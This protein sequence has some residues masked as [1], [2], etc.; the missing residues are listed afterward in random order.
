MINASQQCL[1]TGISPRNLVPF[2]TLDFFENCMRALD[3]F[4]GGGGSSYG[5]RNSGVEIVGA[6]DMWDFA[7]QTYKHNFPSTKVVTDKLENISPTSL[8][9][10]LGSID[11]IVSSPECTNHTC[12]KG[13]KPRDETS[14]DTAL[15]LIR[16]ARTFQ[17]RWLILENVVHMRPWTRYG[18]L[19]TALKKLG[20]NLREQVIDASN[21]GVPQS[22][23]RLFIIGDLETQPSAIINPRRKTR[24]VHDILDEDGKWNTSSLYSPNRAT[25]TL[26]RAERAFASLG[27]RTPFLVVYYGSDAAGGWQTLDR[28]LRTITTIDRFGLVQPKGKKHTLRMLQVPEL[29]KAM[30]FS[31]NYKMP[32]G[33]R[34]NNIKLLGN[35][36]CPPVMQAI[37]KA[38][39]SS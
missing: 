2:A 30:G 24:T 8:K 39:T 29:K 17:P 7:T 26:K 10:K 36:V 20:Y 11:I 6:V 12:A 33:T 28:P 16:Y 22:R 1:M 21:F 4:C 32:F 34:R 15:Q 38:L 9:R 23:R 13:N 3:L 27:K 19:L 31:N 18:E 5:L 37:A 25:D 14:K 35:A